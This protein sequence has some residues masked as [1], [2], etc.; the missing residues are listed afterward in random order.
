[1]D[2]LTTLR[3][4][5]TALWGRWTT[6]QRVGL[7]SAALLSVALVVAT[8]I[9]ATRDEYVVIANQ[10]T[11]QRAAEMKGVLETAQIPAEMNF[12]GS[13][14]A[15]PAT[16]VSAARLALKDQLDPLVTGPSS[17]GS[18]M[19]ES[20]LEKEERRRRDLE[21]RLEK[22]ISQIRGIRSAK[23]HVSLPNPSPFVLEKT[24]PSASI[25]LDLTPGGGFTSD[26]AQNVVALVSRAVEGLS[27]RNIALV[28]TNG[29]QFT[30]DTGFSSAMTAQLEYQREVENKLVRKAESIL[31]RW[32]G[33]DR[34]SVEV[35]ADID[36]QEKQRTETLF[37]PESKVKKEET[38]Q[39]VT[40]TGVVPY[41][42]GTVGA[43]ANL[44]PAT[45]GADPSAGKYNMEDLKVIYENSG[46]V[47][48]MTDLP[49]RILRLTVSAVVDASADDQNP[50]D[51]TAAGAA[52]VAGR[53]LS[54]IEDLIKQAV[55]FDVAR[56][57]EFSIIIDKLAPPAEVESGP[58]T[59]FVWQEYESLIQS[60]V[61][62][63]TALIALVIALLM[64][65]RMKPV[66]VQAAAQE[67]PMSMAD[68]L[69]LRALS[70]QAKANPE[71]V[72]SI[73][74]AWIGEEQKE[75]ASETLT[76]PATPARPAPQ[77]GRRAA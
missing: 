24:E 39:T 45:S 29:R 40:Q 33:P 76:M 74:A 75:E 5:L 56:G 52:T 22:T 64:L 46:T 65:K 60:V 53:D 10:L 34:A 38:T 1:M 70:E 63:M 62:A 77:Q 18:G 55:G 42:V 73:L 48:K 17:A 36:F 30:G 31:A 11:P 49:G 21:T 50:A 15:V 20:P 28:D 47:E 66:V 71:V 69:R 35:T 7:S 43:T 41:P 72:A 13:S 26:A 4:Q 27:T 58:A 16:K 9:W 3:D 6:A 59:G 32:L 68:M 57:D 12:S 67:E 2:L 14:I 61:L 8:L 44:L 19:F 25:V 54:K 51:A 37:D 23:V